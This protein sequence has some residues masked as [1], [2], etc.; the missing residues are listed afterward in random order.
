MESSDIQA[1]NIDFGT[2]SKSFQKIAPVSG[3]H[4]VSHD[5]EKYLGKTHAPG[6]QSSEWPI[7]GHGVFSDI[8]SLPKGNFQVVVCT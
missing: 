3:L 4:Y 2:G 8:E 6:L 5:F 1:H 7:N